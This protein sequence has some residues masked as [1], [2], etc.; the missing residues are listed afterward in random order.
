MC[1]FKNIYTQ[2][3]EVP[4]LGVA[5]PGNSDLRFNFP[6]LPY[7]DY[8]FMRSI[9]VFTV[10]DVSNGPSGPAVIDSATLKKSYLTLYISSKNNNDGGEW[11]RSIPL[12]SLHRTQNSANDP[13]V[14]DLFEM[15]GQMI[16]W[17]KCYINVASAIGNTVNNVFLFN[18]TFEPNPNKTY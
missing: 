13:F 12:T 7:L 10:N 11:I 17:D 16:S 3:V 15:N 4:V 1:G 6:N 18:V 2:T 8:Q 9:E 5:S 14:R